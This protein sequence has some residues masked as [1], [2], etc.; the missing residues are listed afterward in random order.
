LFWNIQVRNNGKYALIDTTGKVIKSLS[1]S[2]V[3][4]PSC[5]RILF[6]ENGKYG[7]Y[8]YKG[9]IAIPAIYTI[10]NPFYEG[11]A[12]VCDNVKQSYGAINTKGAI[13]ILCQY[14]RLEPFSEG[15]TMAQTNTKQWV[16]LNHKDD[17]AIADTF[18]TAYPFNE[19]LAIV[20]K[21]NKSFV[22]DKAGATQFYLPDKS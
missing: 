5:G 19:G 21:G 2:E 20:S 16:Y 14:K 10:A 11:I 6:E 8:D 3:F 1:A 15:F 7:Y 4:A 18:D 22:I 13:V 9:N 17:P 12:I